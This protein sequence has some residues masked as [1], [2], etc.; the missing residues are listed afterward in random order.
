MNT[1][2]FIDLITGF[3]SYLKNEKNKA[4]TTLRA[5][6][7]DVNEYAYFLSGRGKSA[8]LANNAD[9]A[10]FLMDL[11]EKGKS[12]S[13]VNRKLASVRCF[14]DFLQEKGLIDFDPTKNIK[15]PKIPRKELEYLSVEE[16][17]KLLEAPDDSERGIRDR[18]LLEL[19]YATGMRAGELASSKIYDLNLKI[20]F[21]SCTQENG[22]TRI[23]PIGR[24]A[25]AAVEKYL[26][27]A[28]P[29]LI[30]DKETDALFVNYNGEGLTRQGI[31][32]LIKFYGEKTGLE[33]ELSPQL[34]RNS[35]AAHMIQNGADLKSLQDLLGH[36]DITA[37]KLF[38]TV[39]KNRI[40]DVYDRTFPRA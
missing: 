21:I 7:S 6:V 19:M 8:E 12:A 9:V 28:R 29:V 34:I 18:A 13:T 36:E 3:E 27:T 2:T 38:L 25:R 4:S 35:F 37:T 30:K 10:A 24:P 14:Y 22:K 31:W 33:T 16:I 5:Y 1:E 15:S 32:K 39:S 40:M 17:N 23:I 26:Q 20:G 11:K